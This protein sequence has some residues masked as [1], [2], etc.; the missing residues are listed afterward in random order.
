M[1]ETSGPFHLL[2]WKISQRRRCSC[3]YDSREMATMHI[4][5]ECSYSIEGSLCLCDNN[6]PMLMDVIIQI[7]CIIICISI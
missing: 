5:T 4:N 6:K 1:A 7:I 2:M 3:F